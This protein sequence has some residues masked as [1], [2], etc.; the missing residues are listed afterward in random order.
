MYARGAILGLTRGAGRNHIIRAA[1]E[2]IAYQTGDVLHAMEEDTGIPLKE[3]R[4]D[5][6]ASAN[7]FLMQFQADIVGRS[8]RRPM[9]R[10]TTALGAAYLAGLA[11]GVWKDLDEIRS[12]W[13]LDKIYTP[14][15]DAE[16]RDRLY[17][18]WRKA[19]SRAR[20]W[21]D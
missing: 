21:A 6:G 12:Q 3:L 8:I 7:N 20:A 11:T 15:M 19:V 17:A 4:V 10:E 1:L 5:G 13:T 2:S 9:I 14:A 16:E 18:G